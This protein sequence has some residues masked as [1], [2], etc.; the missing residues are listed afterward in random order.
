M[1]CIIIVPSL[2]DFY[3][4][5]HRFSSIGGQIAHEIA[6][7]SGCQSEIILL[8]LL[9]KPCKKDLPAFL[10]HLK[11][12][13]HGGERG[14]VSFFTRYYSY[15][16]EVFEAS[17]LILKKKPD[18]LLFSL[19]AYGYAEELIA[20]AA[21]IKSRQPE[22]PLV[23]AG[24]GV[25]VNPSYFQQSGCLDYLITGEAETSLALFLD[26]LK[27]NGSFENVPGLFWRESGQWRENP[28]ELS[29]ST[30]M[31]YP[32]V[33]TRQS[34]KT[35]SVSVSLTRGCT[36]GCRFCANHDDRTFRYPSAEKVLSRVK[37]DL[38]PVIGARR[39]LLNFEDDNL[40]LC[41]EF[42][43]EILGQIK[44]MIPH[45]VFLAENGLDYRLLTPPLIKKITGLGF[46]K[47]NFTLGSFS[48]E[49]MSGQNRQHRLEH[50]KEVLALLHAMKIQTLTYFIAGFVDDTIEKLGNTLAFLAS[51]AT[52]AG[53]SA[54]YPIPGIPGW[55][56]P[57]VFL[58][59]PPALTLG[60]SFY[61]W[62][63]SLST[64]SLITAFRLTRYINLCK[65]S[66]K[67]GEESELLEQIVKRR[68]IHSLFTDGIKAVPQLDRELVGLFFDR[69]IALKKG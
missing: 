53:M 46:E 41:P 29:S 49:T 45:S 3:F 69:S 16:P 66:E 20:L 63:G 54:F 30:T 13:I 37:S 65:K 62:N 67:S 64:E 50:L 2:R 17:E 23:A 25:K 55:D 1:N 36:M 57:E 39:L 8:P 38:L 24:K 12:F 35:L 9:K 61:P 44:K 59:Y 22:L 27:K 51:Q 7:K 18:L 47:F 52:M 4:T 68:T 48:S 32:F 19:F 42:F 26:A 40:L 6:L 33:V 11:P 58:K 5:P 43:L 10:S 15:G 21:E 31:E 14:P 28:A 60:S 34:Q 56:K